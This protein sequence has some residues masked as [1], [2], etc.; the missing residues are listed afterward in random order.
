MRA[1]AFF[2]IAVF[3]V[4]VSGCENY[5]LDQANQVTFKLQEFPRFLPPEGSVSV[6]GIR[7]MYGDVDGALLVSPLA[8]DAT[9]AAKG[10]K[11]YDIY[12]LPCHGVDGTTSNTPVADKFEMRPAD[13]LNET[14]MSLTEG[15]IYQAILDGAG[16][17]PSYR[18]DLSEAEAWQIV[19]YVLQMQ[20]RN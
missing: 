15:E 10:Q 18:Y 11:L 8:G 14:V 6:A 5:D 13:L 1:T 20:K 7:P 12:C 9:A 16:I 2:L 19:S 4:V 17:M 3:A